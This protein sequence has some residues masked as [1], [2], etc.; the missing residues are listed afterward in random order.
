MLLQTKY[1]YTV[2]YKVF[3][4]LYHDYKKV[5]ELIGL[6]KYSRS[7]TRSSEKN[8]YILWFQFLGTLKNP[9]RMY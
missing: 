9:G 8:T 6:E 1:C 2:E 7:V 4:V 3:G 5:Y